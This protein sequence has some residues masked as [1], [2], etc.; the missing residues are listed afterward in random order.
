MSSGIKIYKIDD[1]IRK[2]E[3]GEIDFDRSMKIIRELATAAAFHTNHNILI[4]LRD[5]T[6]TTNSMNDILKITI[7]MARFKSI[8][9]N[10]IASVIPDNE[11]RLSIAKQFKAC[12]DIK[13]FQYNFFTDFE[14]AIEWLSGTTHLG[15]AND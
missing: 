14:D 6:V 12:L 10:K 4:D 9:K 2:N 5:T 1:F 8:F 11:E 3:S 13:D 15:T 7:E